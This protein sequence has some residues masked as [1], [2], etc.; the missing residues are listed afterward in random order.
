MKKFEKY[1]IRDKKPKFGGWLVRSIDKTV[2]I[3]R[4]IE[5]PYVAIE[6]ICSYTRSIDRSIE[7][8]CVAIETICSYPREM[9]VSTRSIDRS[10]E[11]IVRAIDRIDTTVAIDRSIDRSKKV[12]KVKKVKIWIKKRKRF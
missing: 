11:S 2:S 7:R 12:K 3:D 9:F 4:S 6:T 8:P 10:I 1:C 5:R